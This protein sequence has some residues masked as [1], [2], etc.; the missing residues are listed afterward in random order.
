MVGKFAEI[1]LHPDVVSNIEMGY[2][3]EELI[4]RFSE[5]SNETAGEHFT[6]REVIRLMVNLLFIDDE[7][8]LTKPGIVKTLCD[9]ACGTGGMLSVAEDHLREL[10]PQARL[11]VFGQELNAETYAVCRSDMMLKGQDAT[12]IAF[13]NS[14]SEDQLRGP[15][16]RL[17]ARQSAVRGGVEEG[18]DRGPQGGRDQGL[19]RPVRC[20]PA[21]H[22]RRLVPVPAAH[23]LEDEARRGGRVTAGDRLQRLAA[24]HRRGRFGRVGDPPVDHR[25]RLA[26]GRRR[27]AGPALLQHR[28]LDLLLGGHQPQ[29]ARAAGQGPADRRPR[30]LRQDAQVLG[31]KRKEISAEQIE[32]ITRLYGEFTEGEKVKIFPNEAFGFLRITVERPLRL[33][34]E[35]TD[36]TIAAVMA[37]KAVQKLPTMTRRP[38][39]NCWTNTVG[40]YSRRSGT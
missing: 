15:A 13:G 30:V 36:E 27:P 14:F 29:G 31:E 34:W 21:A 6:P 18:R 8:V 28:H 11:E 26:G 32:E 35:V 12:H 10:N 24:L 1:D 17:P 3:Y 2:L 23:D 7:D 22:Q 5:L 16:V 19:R 37:A 25:E 38:S 9:P 40:R 33:R 39:V 4:R 20:R